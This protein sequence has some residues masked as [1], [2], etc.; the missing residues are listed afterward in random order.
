MALSGGRPSTARKLLDDASRQ[1]F[2]DLSVSR[3]RLRHLRVRILK[4]VV[5]TAMS[6]EDRAAF[7]DL[8]NQLPPL[9][10]TSSTE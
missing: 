6:D 7:L 3:D 10:A 2:F 4:P 5:F 8:A 1:V 9:H